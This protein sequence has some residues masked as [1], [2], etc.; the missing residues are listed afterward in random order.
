MHNRKPRRYSGPPTYGQPSHLRLVHSAPSHKRHGRLKFDRA[1]AV[2]AVLLSS[3]AVVLVLGLLA[4]Y[5]GV[6]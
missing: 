1:L 2:A 6:H 4:E 5:A 3:A